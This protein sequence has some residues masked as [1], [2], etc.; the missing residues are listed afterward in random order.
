MTIL[1]SF[2]IGW[3]SVTGKCQNCFL[4]R[5]SIVGT[6]LRT[7]GLPEDI[8]ADEHHQTRDGEKNYVATTVGGGCVLGAAVCEGAGT[9]DLN[10]AS[11]A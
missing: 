4:G 3:I 2:A 7:G 1:A 10:I 8:L 6:T 9:D 11:L 5:N